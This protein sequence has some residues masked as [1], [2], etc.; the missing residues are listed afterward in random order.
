MNVNLI[1]FLLIIFLEK[2]YNDDSQISSYIMNFELT[3]NNL[4]KVKEKRE[5][6]YDNKTFS[7]NEIYISTYINNSIINSSVINKTIN[8]SIEM[9]GYFFSY[10][11]IMYKE[12]I[13]NPEIYTAFLDENI[14]FKL[15]NISDNLL[16][17]KNF[18]ILS[19][20][21][22]TDKLI[23]YNYIDKRII[24]ENYTNNTN[25]F[26][27]ND[28]TEEEKNIITE[29]NLCY[30]GSSKND[31][32]KKFVCK[33]DYILL[34]HEDLPKDDVYLAKQIEDKYSIAYFDNML[35]YSI[36]PFEYLDY[37]FTSFF[38]ELNDR[39]MK[40]YYETFGN[41]K[42]RIKYYYIMCPKKTIDIYTKR[43]KLSIIIN[44]F[45]Y[46][47]ENLFVDSF[48]FLNINDIDTDNY[49]FNILFESDRTNFRL[50]YDFLSNLIFC[51]YNHSTYIYSKNRIDY[52]EYLTDDNSEDFEKWL[53][54]LTT[55]SFT[56]V[57]LIFTVIGCFH[58]RKI[59]LELQ[60]MLKSDI[61]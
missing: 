48:D 35:R 52:T 55:C 44:K 8:E 47:V 9:N 56:F 39:C 12:V 2:I 24:I 36:F 22:I 26:D 6:Y 23:L 53:Y 38:S 28:L 41:G 11:Y 4:T 57:L 25:L 30:N 5:F 3:N 14:T 34:G 40:D 45:S 60:E 13:N 59:K 21:N 50:G 16:N 19:L 46:R 54:I 27:N 31:N 29:K 18:S 20:K 10:F 42:Q 17:Q 37:F 49:Y 43:R 7:L 51:D 61:K 58:S 32:N 15:V 1:F 33:L